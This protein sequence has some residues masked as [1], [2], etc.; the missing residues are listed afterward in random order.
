MQ[1]LDNSGWSR[2]LEDFYHRRLLDPQEDAKIRSHALERMKSKPSWRNIAAE[3]QLIQ[4]DVS[5]DLLRDAT[6]ALRARNPKGLVFSP[7]S[8]ERAHV[9]N[10]WTQW[11]QKNSNRKD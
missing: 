4:G 11:W 6:L 10:E 9:V 2:A 3:I 1:E 7:G 5:D 8:G